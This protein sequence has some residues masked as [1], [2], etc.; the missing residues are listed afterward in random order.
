MAT[1]TKMNG[2]MVTDDELKVKN[3]D[4]AREVEWCGN[5]VVPLSQYRCFGPVTFTVHGS[6]WATRAGPQMAAQ[7]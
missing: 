7:L 5:F 4:L 6:T 2:I 1:G 3:L